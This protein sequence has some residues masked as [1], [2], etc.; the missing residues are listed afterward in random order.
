MRTS[1]LLSPLVNYETWHP[2]VQVTNVGGM[3]Q[4]SL[5][6]GEFRPN[7]HHHFLP[8]F[9]RPAKTEHER[10]SLKMA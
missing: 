4:K 9:Y 6:S 2:G 1:S 8:I 10:E 3:S 5:C 7:W